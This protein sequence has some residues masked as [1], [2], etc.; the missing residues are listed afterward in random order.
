VATEGKFSIGKY[1]L[2]RF[3]LEA[4]KRKNERIRHVRGKGLIL[5]IELSM[6]GAPYV[7]KCMDRGLL[8]NCTNGNVLRF[9]P[10]LI[11]SIPDV[12]KAMEILEIVLEE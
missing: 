4:L 1:T 10:P 5:A 7:L 6:P 11:L 12:D 9:V 8:I 2:N 3:H